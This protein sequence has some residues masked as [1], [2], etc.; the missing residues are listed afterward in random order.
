MG[1]FDKASSSDERHS[2]AS[3]PSSAP[4]DAPGQLFPRTLNLYH[5]KFKNLKTTVMHLG[6]HQSQPMY[7]VT[8]NMG[9]SGKVSLTLHN[10]PDISTPALGT[11]ESVGMGLTESIITIPSPPARVPISERMRLHQTWS[12]ESYTFPATLR[13]GEVGNFVWRRSHSEAVRE[14][15]GYPWGWKLVRA[16]SNDEVVAVL[17]DN[18]KVGNEVAKFGF[19]GSGA[20]GELGDEWATMA[21]LAAVRVWQTIASNNAYL[22]AIANA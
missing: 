9:L 13:N 10:G 15:D 22:G 4:V 6:E 18:K 14:L 3:S 19:T 8:V 7:A 5:D 1:I 2:V 17:A 21:V 20:T 12:S 16:D 11:V